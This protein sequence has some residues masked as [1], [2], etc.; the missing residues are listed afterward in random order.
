MKTPACAGTRA[1]GRSCGTSSPR[2]G[3]TLPNRS[4][5]SNPWRTCARR[6]RLRGDPSWSEGLMPRILLVADDPT[7]ARALPAT[8]AAEGFEVH[9]GTADPTGS[10]VFDLILYHLSSADDGL[11]LPPVN[12]TP[13]VVRIGRKDPTAVLNC[14]EAGAASVIPPDLPPAE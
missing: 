12:G 3:R 1:P 4:C 5:P 11:L 6:V 14:L 13:F 8:L 2:R 9:I 7:V 10:D